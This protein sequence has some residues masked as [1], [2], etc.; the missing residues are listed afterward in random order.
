MAE[1]QSWHRR[2]ARGWNHKPAVHG[3]H[4]ADGVDFLHVYRAG[5]GIRPSRQRRCILAPVAVLLVYAAVRYGVAD[6]SLEL[7]R[8]ALTAGD[9]RAGVEHYAAYEKQKLPGTSA[10]LWYS[11]S[12]LSLAQKTADPVVKMQAVT[13]A[14][15]AG[16]GAPDGGGP[17][18][19]LVQ[20]CRHLC[21]AE[22]CGETEESLRAATAA[23]PHWSKPHQALAQLLFLQGRSA[24]GAKEAALAA[25][26]QR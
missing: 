20:P 14:G 9:L 26:L 22:R 6:R 1:R 17:F 4:G 10:D 21:G 25:D 15:I 7:A 13:Q 8:R 3:F 18:R 23:H 16:E 5:G 12:L 19:R 24:E 2:S 11:R